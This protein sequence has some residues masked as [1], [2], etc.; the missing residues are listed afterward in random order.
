MFEKGFHVFGA[1]DAGWMGSL[2]GAIETYEKACVAAMGHRLV[3]D[4]GDQLATEVLYSDGIHDGLF[5][6]D[7]DVWVYEDE[8]GNLDASVEPPADLK[9]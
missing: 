1:G 9:P 2:D 3:N 6:K 7:G 5:S 4:D 8:F